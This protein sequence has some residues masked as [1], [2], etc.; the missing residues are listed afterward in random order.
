MPVGSG[1]KAPAKPGEAFE[2][3]VAAM[4]GDHVSFATM[5]GMSDDWFFATVPAGI[6]LFDDAGKP[7]VGD[8]TDRIAI[9]DAGTEIDQEPAIG[10]DTGPQQAGPDTGALDPVRQVREVPAAIV[11]RAGERAPARHPRD[12]M[13]SR[14]ARAAAPGAPAA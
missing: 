13:S 9:Y 12:G 2:L 4:P 8:V 6:A 11:R 3:S 1:V 14:R 10:P 5:F 7:M